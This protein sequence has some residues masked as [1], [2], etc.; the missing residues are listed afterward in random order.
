MANRS[1][2]GVGSADLLVAL[3]NRIQEGRLSPDAL[4]PLARLLGVGQILVRN[5]L[6][7][8]RFETVA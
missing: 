1:G 2:R 4:A 8:E 6:D 5:D 3:D 7:Y